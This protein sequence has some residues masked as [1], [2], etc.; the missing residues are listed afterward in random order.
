MVPPPQP[1]LPVHRFDGTVSV[2][3]LL[4]SPHTPFASPVRAFEQASHAKSHAL[5]QHT[6]STQL[7]DAHSVPT[8]QLSPRSF[9]QLPELSQV[10]A[11]LQ[12]FGATL[13]SPALRLTQL[14]VVPPSEQVLQA[15]QF[16]TTVVGH[17]PS[18]EQVPPWRVSPL[19]VAQA[20]P[21]VEHS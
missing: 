15:A 11:P 3:T 16:S 8:L 12:V 18:T 5:S 1:V 19:Q 17:A 14:E 4:M 2:V 6:P 10:D 9:S 21:C 13:S 7:P 20:S